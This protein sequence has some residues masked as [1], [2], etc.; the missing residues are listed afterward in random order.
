[1]AQPISTDDVMEEVRTHVRARLRTELERIDPGSPLLTRE[2]FDE[3]EAIYR[4]ALARRRLLM[5]P[6]LLLDE[7]EWELATNLRFTS[8]RPLAGRLV[9]FA[10]RRLV[11]PLT[12]W[13][14]E[15]SRDNFER[16]ARVND[17]LMATIETLVVEVITLRRDVAQLRAGQP[18]SPDHAPDV[19]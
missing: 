9:L 4:K 3:A 14:Y 5:M 7:T 6:S 11:L 19:R 13:L 15:F 2:L 16:Q 12:R 18:A 8:H 17:T 10:K 1:V